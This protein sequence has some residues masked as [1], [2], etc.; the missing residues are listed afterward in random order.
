VKRIALLVV[1]LSAVVAAQGQPKLRGRWGSRVTVGGGAAPRVTIASPSLAS[2][3]TVASASLTL[4]GTA[5]STSGAPITS[6]T[7]ENT[8][9]AASGTAV[10][11]TNWETAG[12]S[13]ALT[14]GLDTFLSTAAVALAGTNADT[15]G[16]AWSEAVN[17]TAAEYISRRSVDYIQPNT[18]VT[19]QVS[20]VMINLL[21]PSPAITG[22]NYDVSVKLVHDSAVG[23]DDGAAIIFGYS[24]SSNYCSVLLYGSAA[25]TD[26][27][28][29]KRAAG[30]L[31]VL[32]SDNITPAASDVIKIEVRGSGL[33]VTQ[34]GVSVLTATDTFCDNAVGV[35]VG[36]GAFRDVTTD[37]ATT[38]SKLDDF[39]VVDQ[40]GSNTALT[41]QEGANTIVVTATDA[42][43]N[44]GTDTVVVTYE[45]TDATDPIVTI[46]SP[47]SSP[48][49]STSTSALTV[50]GTCTD[51]TAPTA[52]TVSCATCTP[53]APSN[54]G[55]AAS[56]SFA[57]TAQTA[58][59]NTITVTCADAAKN[60]AT[61]V[62]T[63]TY[64][65]ADVTAPV[66]TITTNG[67]SNLSTSNASDTIAGTCTDA[68]GCTQILP[69][70][71][72]CSAGAVSGLG[73]WSFTGTWAVGANIVSVGGRD[74]A[75]NLA[76]PD[77]ITVTYTP[78][79]ITITT[80]SM[81]NG[82]DDDAYPSTTLASTGGTAPLTW[83]NNGAG[84]SLNDGDAHCAGLVISS[85]GV[86]SG[87]PTTAGT[88]DWT[89]KVTDN[90]AATDTQALSIVVVAAGAEGPHDYFTDLI[91]RGDCWKAFSLRPLAGQSTAVT[92]CAQSRYEKQL[93]RA[94]LGGYAQQ[95]SSVPLTLTYCF[96]GSE[97]SGSCL[98]TDT[99]PQKQDAAKL[100]LPM[101]ISYEGATLAAPI[102]DNDLTITLASPIGK[103]AGAGGGLKIGNEILHVTGMADQSGTTIVVTQRGA[104]GTT[105]AAHSAGAA[106]SRL[107]N[108]NEN[109]VF[110]PLG[111][112]GSE[113]ANY[114]F[115]WD[116]FP[117][118][119][120][121]AN[122]HGLQVYKTFHFNSSAGDDNW[123]RADYGFIPYADDNVPTFNPAS[124]VGVVRGRRLFGLTYPP[125]TPEPPAD[126]HEPMLPWGDNG[127]AAIV[128]PNV[129]GRWFVYIET[130]AEGD[131]ANFTNVTTLNSAITSATQ[132]QIT[133]ACDDALFGPNCPPF[134]TAQVIAGAS[135]PG[136]SIKIGSE[137]LTITSGT[138]SGD[139]TTLTVARGQYGTTAATHLNGADVGVVHDF[140][141]LWYADENNNAVEL[142]DRYPAH[143]D[144]NG[145]ESVR[146][147]LL[148]LRIEFSTSTDTILQ[149]RI[150]AGQQDLVVY[151]RNFAILKNPPADW[152][153]LRVKPVR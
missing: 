65:A 79:P 25:A 82:R 147:E 63:S 148:R 106:V 117:T 81:P 39:T 135:W 59:A 77:T 83:S 124:D 62:L 99:N 95:G 74:E 88:C 4:G 30:T 6:V 10:G 11:T 145:A 113:D 40:D 32:D 85:A 27:Y 20:P 134:R 151:L 49:Y 101:W 26:A 24:D 78:T 46:Q 68:V 72:V 108:V 84:T 96:T 14:V 109:Q 141:T 139:T 144:E 29:L 7:W 41:L 42:L 116:T 119:S 44:V 115:I 47:T 58:G 60:D 43:S 31:T 71:D 28:L 128:K 112:T 105:A 23:A 126:D 51:N 9:T 120:L 98:T 56:F 137:I 48:T 102:D 123:F 133:I 107:S 118:D 142:L 37:D 92:T 16:G 110:L 12:Q 140:I 13:S 122:R 94:G 36:F 149:A 75:G 18:S 89:A 35:G 57:F 66:V 114:L 132:T 2:A 97:P 73:A 8:T 129:W 17:T 15:V 54:T 103:V 3:F 45:L 125:S 130:Q 143:L 22:T 86:V 50:T 69:T 67:G 87:T 93:L 127:G 138:T 91:A 150:N 19:S 1:L 136:R 131:P 90:V 121:I 21:T 152:S 146:G 55:T 33:T 38:A 64:T 104:F 76:T 53:A 100:V 111:T 52:T 80:T 61:D 34:N 153:A 70:C 5:E